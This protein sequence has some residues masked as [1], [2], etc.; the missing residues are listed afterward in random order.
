MTEIFS[1]SA[2]LLGEEGMKK[3]SAAKV[4]VFGLGGV[5]GYAVEA[6]ARAGVGTLHLIDNDA[7]A[8]SNRNRQ[9][10]ALSSTVGKKKTEV[11]VARVKE[12]NPDCAVVGFPLF[13]LPENADEFDLSGY[14]YVVDAVDTVSAKIELAVRCN[15]LGVPLVSC[16][17]TGNKLHAE[18][19]YVS[20][21]FQTSVCP[22]ARVMRREL[23]KRGVDRLKVVCSKELPRTPLFDGADEAN[24]RAPASVP[25][26]PPVAGFL[27]AQTVILDLLKMQ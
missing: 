27:L 5:G 2:R 25:F 7:V 10:Y 13:Y 20:D 23:K 16:M 24:G 3:L 8:P 12:I 11:A 17:G 21:L 14:D 1:R 4:A 18:E 19:L 26:V 22:L 9:I 6:L 15:R